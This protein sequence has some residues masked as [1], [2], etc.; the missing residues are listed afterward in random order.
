MKIT[1]N[2]L[3]KKRTATCCSQ[4]RRPYCAKEK[5]LNGNKIKNS[6]GMSLK[7]RRN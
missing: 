7:K 4:Q 1:F 5:A 2:Y 6:C 3:K